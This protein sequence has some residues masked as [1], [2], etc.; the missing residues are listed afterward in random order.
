PFNRGVVQAFILPG[1]LSNQQA[2]FPF[3]VEWRV[4]PLGKPNLH[5]LV[6]ETCLRVEVVVETPIYA[7]ISSEKNVQEQY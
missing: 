3:I 6:E 4:I 7:T 2:I 1:D 5:L